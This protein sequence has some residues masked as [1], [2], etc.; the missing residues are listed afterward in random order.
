MR[1]LT[2]LLSAHFVLSGILRPLL[3]CAR[4]E[5]HLTEKKKKEKRDR[6]VKRNRGGGMKALSYND[7]ILLVSHLS[8]QDRTLIQAHLCPH[9][10]IQENVSIYENC[11][12]HPSEAVQ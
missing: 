7:E 6:A 2:C 5:A 8:V 10:F 11:S 12:L 3:Q 9:D 1:G 4:L